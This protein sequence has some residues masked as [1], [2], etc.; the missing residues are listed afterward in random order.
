MHFRGSTTR[1]KNNETRRDKTRRDETRRDETRRDETR[2][3]ETR[4]DETRWGAKGR[5]EARRARNSLSRQVTSLFLDTVLVHLHKCTTRQTALFR[6]RVID[7]TSI[8]MN[9]VYNRTVHC[10]NLK[11][12]RTTQPERQRIT[13][14]LPDS[15]R[16]SSPSYLPPLVCSTSRDL[17]GKK[18][19]Y[20]KHWTVLPWV[21]FV[22]IKIRID[23]F[24]DN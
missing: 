5:D 15:P 19:N 7:E 3:N 4:R 21:N 22:L 14:C 2:R 13:H 23:E 20:T 12:Q 9:T 10:F 17:S 18:T 16:F 1:K 11:K 24:G 6:D 8:A